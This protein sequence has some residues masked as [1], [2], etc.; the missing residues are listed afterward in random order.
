MKTKNLHPD[1]FDLVF[2]G[3]GAANS[4]LFLHLSRNGQLQQKRIAIFEPD[5]KQS[6]DR[7]FC[8]WSTEKE[9]SQLNLNHLIS[10]Q[11]EYATA[12]FK[13]QESIHPYTYYHISGI[14]LYEATKFEIKQYHVQ[15]FHELVAN[16][17]ITISN[18]PITPHS[19]S[20]NS[21]IIHTDNS[22]IQ[23]PVIFDSRPPQFNSPNKNEV[24]MLQ[25]FYGW[26]IE[27]EN[28]VFET[29]SFVMMDFSIPQNNSTQFLYIL[30]FKENQALVEITAFHQNPITQKQAESILEREINKKFGK[31]SISAHE[32]GIIPMATSSIKHG[33]QHPFYFQTGARAG[34]IKPST[35][36]SF[37]KSAN[38]AIKIG[39]K[40]TNP[41]KKESIRYKFTQKSNDYLTETKSRFGFYDRLL[42]SI[43]NQHPQKGKSIFESLFQSNSI[44]EVITFL[45]EES[46]GIQEIKLLFSL[47]LVPFL[48]A[49]F[50]D[51]L[52]RIP[53]KSLLPLLITILLYVF[54]LFQINELG[55]GVLLLGLLIVGIPHGAVDHLLNS[56]NKSANITPSFITNYLLKMGFMGVIWWINP[57]IAIGVFLLYSAWHF[58]ETEFNHFSFVSFF[59]GLSVLGFFLFSHPEELNKILQQM[60][61]KTIDFNFQG[62]FYVSAGVLIFCQLHR[63]IDRL[64]EIIWMFLALKLS[65]LEGFG[66]YFVFSHSIK[67][68]LDILR[69]YKS[70]VAELY[71]LALPFSMGAYM[72]LGGFYYFNFW[73]SP[74]MTGLFFIFLSCISF[75]HVFAMHK[76]Y[77]SRQLK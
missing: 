76:F 64:W 40:L 56:E 6:N 63:G 34:N 22:W 77:G 58:G 3:M 65:L 74:G 1:K 28:P 13:I 37:L 55:L 35:G 24:F 9:I 53:W 19:N 54:N 20:S 71:K 59:W 33:I 51:I 57:N 36:Y 48:T 72:M 21:L 2:I 38:H 60:S 23:T 66:L 10:K 25:S 70:S 46:R 39:Q 4:L 52:Y 14:D 5:S 61:V 8:F 7:T 31:F 44:A 62:A 18:N 15:Y 17:Q 67:S 45:R 68:A 50:R 43:L 29:H 32:T 30:P 73:H 41:P 12:G 27:T 69:E 26:T 75:P 49:A 42:L 11:W 16:E 47:P